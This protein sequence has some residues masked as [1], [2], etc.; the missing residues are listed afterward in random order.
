MAAA[1][2]IAGNIFNEQLNNAFGDKVDSAAPATKETVDNVIS[3]VSIL[4]N[5]YD[6][7][8]G[9]VNINIGATYYSEAKETKGASAITYSHNGKLNGN[10]HITLF[11]ASFETCRFLASTLFHEF[12]HVQDFRSGQIFNDFNRICGGNLSSS[13]ARQT[14]LYL[15]EIRAYR[16][17]LRV[18]G[19]PFTSGYYKAVNYLTEMGIS[20]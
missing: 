7:F 11:G 2:E 9:E 14:A 20:F 13:Q 16:E 5:Q 1:G 6:S 3:N 15:S 19:Q 10:P 18:T 17:G 4:K 12:I 8:N